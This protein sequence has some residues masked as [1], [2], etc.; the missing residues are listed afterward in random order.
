[1]GSALPA[2]GARP[3]TRS[4]R[5]QQ[6]LQKANG[7]R[8]IRFFGHVSRPRYERLRKFQDLDARPVNFEGRQGGIVTR[9]DA[10]STVQRMS[11]ANAVKEVDD[12]T[13][14]DGESPPARHTTRLLQPIQY[15]G[16]MF[17]A[18]FTP[19]NHIVGIQLAESSKRLPVEGGASDGCEALKVSQSPLTNSWIEYPAAHPE[20]CGR[21]DATA[22]RANMHQ[23]IAFRRE[24]HASEGSPNF[25]QKRLVFAVVEPVCQ[26]AS[27]N[28]VA[29]AVQ[30]HLRPREP[31]MLEGAQRGTA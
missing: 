20:S 13:V 19:R 30:D 2:D 5:V 28:T 27:R 31:T 11:G 17:C 29:D 12:P 18:A 24:R 21:L 8:V 6:L 9:E 3:G 16:Q 10:F 7:Q 26:I 23:I 4:H 25:R 1:M 15:S 14:C 22:E